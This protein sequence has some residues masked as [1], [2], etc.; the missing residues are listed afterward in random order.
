MPI[1]YRILTPERLVIAE[2]EG[3][4]TSE[5]LFSYQRE[6]WSRADV[7]GFDELVDMS[8]VEQVA[9]ESSNTV[10]ELA[11]LSSEMDEPHTP[12]KMAIVASDDGHYGLGRMY[13]AYRGLARKSMKSVR[14]FRTME[15]ARA[16]LER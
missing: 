2:P 7:V 5:D 9:Y 4:L 11:Q 10:R 1:R 12:T 8:R 13:E 6:V 16:W 14:T 3:T 15:E